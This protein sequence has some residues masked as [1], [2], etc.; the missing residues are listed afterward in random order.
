MT[1]VSEDLSARRLVAILRLRHTITNT[2]ELSINVFETGADSVLN[3][4]LD[5]LLDETSGEG[6]DGLVKKLVLRVTDRELEGINLD[7][8]ILDVEDGGLVLLSGGEVDGGGETLSTEDDI[9]ETLIG[10][11]D[12]A[13]VLVVEG[14]IA[15]IGLDLTECE[16]ELV[17][18]LVLDG[19]VGRELH[20]IVSL[21]RDVAV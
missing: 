1:Y 20:E 8:D 5:L 19:V 12:T 17:M 13:T 4:L 21:H 16:G 7:I 10:D 2:D 6:A 14:N 15:H 3:S 9:G 18:A 11:L